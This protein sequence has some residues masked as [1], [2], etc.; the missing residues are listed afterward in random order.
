MQLNLL[1]KT[2]G[3]EGIIQKQLHLEG[4]NTKTTYWAFKFMK[5]NLL[6]WEHSK[7]LFIQN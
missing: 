7:T 2:V 6:N 1:F 4:S 3:S 5:G